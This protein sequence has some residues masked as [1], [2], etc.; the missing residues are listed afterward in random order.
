MEALLQNIRSGYKN[1]VSLP[2]L[3]L[4]FSMTPEEAMFIIMLKIKL[5]DYHPS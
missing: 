2:Q 1:E 3:S 5:M 4:D